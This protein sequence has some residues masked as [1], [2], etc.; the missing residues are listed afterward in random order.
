MYEVLLSRQAQKYY[1]R[2]DSDTASRLNQCLDILVVSPFGGGDIKPLKGRKGT[3][4]FRVGDLR[5]IYEVDAGRKKVKVLT[6]L[7]RGQAYKGR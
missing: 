4:R 6:I 5:V 2:V 3:Y 7:P 1:E